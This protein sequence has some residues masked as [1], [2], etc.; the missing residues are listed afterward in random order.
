M[1]KPDIKAA[2]AAS[3]Q[4]EQE[5]VEQRFAKADSYFGGQDSIPTTQP[6]IPATPPRPP[7]TKVIRDG[8]TMPTTDYE[9]IS[10]IQAICLKAGFSVTKS[11]VVR[12]G[13]HA[14]HDLSTAELQGLFGKLER[15]KA[16]RP[17]L[18]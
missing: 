6:P 2:L 3:L 13:L 18:K 12:A 1:N 4:G 11:E 9:L 5:A 17:P 14:L 10:E 16:G 8:F 15:V 7:H